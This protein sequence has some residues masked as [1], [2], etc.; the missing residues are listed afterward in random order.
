MKNKEKKL[1]KSRKKDKEL[2]EVENKKELKRSEKQ[3]EKS[4]K[5]K[6]KELKR[7]GERIYALTFFFFFAILNSFAV[8]SYVFKC[9]ED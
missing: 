8:Y 3:K 9:E 6:E 1:K 5:Q 7:G 2:K 4:G